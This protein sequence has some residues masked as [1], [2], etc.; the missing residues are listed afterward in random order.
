MSRLIFE[1]ITIIENNDPLVDL[2]DYPFV[3]E[4]VYYQQGHSHM[5]QVQLRKGVADRLALIQ[6]SFAGKYRF[7]VWDGYRPRSV[8]DAIYNAYHNEVAAAHPEWSE[9]QINQQVETFVT[10]AS[11]Q[12]RIPPHATGAAIDL[13]LVDA[14]GQELNMGTAFDSF[15][16]EAASMYYEEDTLDNQVRD[17]RRLLRGA[18]VDAGFRAD[19]DEWWHFDYGN[20][21]W[22]SVLAQPHAFYGEIKES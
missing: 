16:P 7:K 21:I 19:D 11:E 13:T 14:K 10:K 20:Q 8:Q 9:Q 15:S 5:P 4:P 2:G 6:Q 3:V 12:K 22:A 1:S 18:M 17:N